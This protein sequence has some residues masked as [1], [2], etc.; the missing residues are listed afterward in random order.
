VN[1]TDI[2]GAAWRKSSRSPG[3]SKLVFTP[4]EW[5]AFTAGVRDGEIDIG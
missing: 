4:A 5:E 2:P 3:G 1:S